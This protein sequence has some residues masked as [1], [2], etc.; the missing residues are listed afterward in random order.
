MKKRLLALAL[1]MLCCASLLTVPAL[2][3]EIPEPTADFYAN[4]FANVLSS[5]T[6]G[7]VV[8]VNDRLYPATSAQVV[9]VTVDFLDGANIENYAYQL[10]NDWEI[11]AADSNRGVLLLL[12]I[13]E[14]N[15]WCVQGT[16][17][18]DSLDSAAIKEILN[19]YLEP[20]FAAGDYDAGV[21]KT[22][23]A[24]SDRLTSLYG[25]SGDGQGAVVA[26]PVQQQTATGG[27][28]AFFGVVIVLFVIIVMLVVALSLSRVF[29]P[30]RRG[31]F[32]FYPPP[33]HFHHRHR[34]PHYPPPPPGGFRGPRGP[35]GGGF[36]G[37]GGFTGGG[38]A[39][40]GGFGG[41]APRGGGGGGTRGGGAG[42]G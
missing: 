36:G 29:R 1:L 41:G 13:G 35:R 15:Y 32:G 38:G 2:A 5:D 10:F 4:D 20:D 37:F 31:F 40:R 6:E 39:G 18:Q 11:G 30:R 27:I 8:S 12:A 42:R 22:V 24:I 16:G 34:P 17:L 9:V 23:Q 28:P 7:E 14:E 21:R 26:P 33:P 25:G 19:T 3:A